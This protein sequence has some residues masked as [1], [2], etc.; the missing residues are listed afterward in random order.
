MKHKEKMKSEE[1]QNTLPAANIYC[2]GGTEA[3]KIQTR[4][5]VLLCLCGKPFSAAGRFNKNP[6]YPV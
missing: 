6:C 2:H 3:Q 5:S 4:V 1:R